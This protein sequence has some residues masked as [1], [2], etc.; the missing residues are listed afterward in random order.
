MEIIILDCKNTLKNYA[1]IIVNK[2]NNHCALI[3]TV[4]TDIILDYLN[5]NHLIL[6]Y[7]LNTHHHHDHIGGNLKLQHHFNCD[8][9]G[10]AQDKH[11]ISGI[12]HPVHAGDMITLFDGLLNFKVIPCDGH[13]IGSI[14]YYADDKNWLFS[15]DTLF[16]LG[17]GRR[18]EG[19]SEQFYNTLQTIASLPDKTLIYGSH[20]YTL[21]NIAFAKT[22]IS[23]DYEYYS[24]FLDYCH[25]QYIQR[26]NNIPTIPFTLE[27]QKKFNPFLLCDNSTI[28]KALQQKNRHHSDIFGHMR[29]LKDNF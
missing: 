2:D 3:D 15:G 22:V 29:L 21:D 28:Q 7:I 13:T 16:N 27:S 19:T 5:D 11:R 23:A 14:A 8:I 20:E 4:D 10:N 6:K 18:F 25:Q 1:F 26:E 12:T 9:Y 24:D 17:C